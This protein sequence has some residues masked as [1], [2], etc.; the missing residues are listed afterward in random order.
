MKNPILES[1]K[2]AIRSPYAWPGGY[3]V[4]TVCL[5]GEFLCCDCA[6][7]E[8]RQIVEDTAKGYHGNFECIGTEVYWEGPIEYCA[9]CK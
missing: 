8:Y 6:R 3:P 2:N 7:K 5:D 4:Y 1:V 9:N